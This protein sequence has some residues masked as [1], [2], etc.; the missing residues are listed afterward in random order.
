MGYKV[1]STTKQ[2][3]PIRINDPKLA[4][5]EVIVELVCTFKDSHFQVIQTERCFSR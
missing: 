5:T 2:I 1:S 3:S 4:Q